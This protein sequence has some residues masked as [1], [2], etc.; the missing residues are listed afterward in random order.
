MALEGI[1]KAVDHVVAP[2]TSVPHELP[3]SRHSKRILLVV[4]SADPQLPDHRS[5][6]FWSEL[7]HPFQ[8]FTKAGWHCDLVSETGAALPDEASL[9]KLGMPTDLKFWED[10]QYPLHKALANIKRPTDLNP[11]DY[12]GVFVAGGHAC[13]VDMP[14]A[15]TLQHLIAQIYEQGGVIAAVCHGPA[16]F[17]NLRLSSGA[18][19][20]R[21]LHATGFPDKAEEEMGL[22]QFM[23]DHEYVTMKQAVESVG[24]IWEEPDSAWGSFVRTSGRV[25][26]GA[27]PNSAAQ[28]A[29]DAISLLDKQAP[30]QQQ[31]AAGGVAV[32]AGKGTGKHSETLIGKE[33]ARSWQGERK[34]A[35]GI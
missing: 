3:A 7:L 9:G 33:E 34:A 2:M 27:N 26:T 14:T 24:G 15:S 20:L 6:Y 23:K 35:S 22:T 8:E 32:D 30:R 10:K 21:G 12:A 13:C 29:K 25:V 19:L 4:S 5:G 1:R 28:V 17:Q 11:A 16:I 31:A 18:F